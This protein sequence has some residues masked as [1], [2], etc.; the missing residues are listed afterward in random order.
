[1]P[2]A[3]E[4]KIYGAKEH[5]LKNIDLVIPRNKLV[6]FTGL[7]GSGKSSLA[8]DTLFA[9]GQRRYIETFSAYA[10]QFI[11]GMERPDVDKIEGLSPVISI[12]QKTV[13]KSPRSTVGTITELYDFLRLL[14]SR[15]ASAYSSET[16]ELMVKYTDDQLANLL[17]TTYKSKK[18]AILASKV[19]AR[20]GHYRELFE[21]IVKTGYTKVRVDGVIMDI[22]PGMKLDRYKVHDIEIVVDRFPV[23]DVD[24]IRITKAVNTAFSIG[25]DYL[26]IFDYNE[27]KARKYSR[28]YICP[29]SGISYPD[30]EPNLFSFNSPYGACASC[31]GI[32]IVK[33][34]DL[35]KVIPNKTKSIYD[36]GIE[37]LGK[38]KKNWIFQ[39][40]QKILDHEGISLKKPIKEIDP[41]IL[42]L[43]LNGVNSFDSFDKNH[44][45]FEG[46]LSFLKRH[47]QNSSKKIQRWAQ[48]YTTNEVCPSCSGARLKKDALFFKIS[49]KNIAELSQMGLN[50]L[51]QWLE[52]VDKNL[53]DKQKIPSPKTSPIHLLDGKY[54]RELLW[55]LSHKNRNKLPTE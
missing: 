18:V 6:V 47:A 4:I 48:S 51:R 34:A 21:Q 54:L 19:R 15:V 46:V 17:S 2:K 39:E 3:E 28:K 13:S 24:L 10:R 44:E 20:K 7:S 42:S 5:N 50:Q 53:N 43:L 31:A 8:F 49:N 41:E 23:Q 11:G 52:T 38:Y 16:G 37:P 29:T 32:G 40:I 33:N 12:E 36:G 30:P 27:K 14:F 55:D 9:E 22:V 45:G 25:D 1:M 35:N 26:V